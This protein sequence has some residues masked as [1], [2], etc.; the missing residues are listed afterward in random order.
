MQTSD[1]VELKLIRAFALQ[2]WVDLKLCVKEIEIG[3]R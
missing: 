2:D 3:L 1:K